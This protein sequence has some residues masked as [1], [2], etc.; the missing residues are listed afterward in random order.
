MALTERYCQQPLKKLHRRLL[1]HTNA[2]LAARS[3]G[4]APRLTICAIVCDVRF[5]QRLRARLIGL[6]SMALLFSQIAVAAY[7]VVIALMTAQAIGRAT[8]QQT[9]AAIAVAVGAGFFM[10]SDS[11]LAI[12]R[13]VTPLPFSGLWVLST[14]FTAQALILLHVLRR[15]ETP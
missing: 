12:N 4:I 11:L 10:L 1:G 2:Q 5:S 13:F 8:E 9:P 6:L 14:Y 15:P 3:A 7:V